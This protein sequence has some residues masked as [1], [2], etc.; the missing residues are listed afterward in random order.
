MY[1][2]VYV[3]TCISIE[4]W[5]RLRKYTFHGVGVCR[6]QADEKNNTYIYIYIY[7]YFY[8]YIYIYIYI[9]MMSVVNTWNN[10]L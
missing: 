10:H 2:E 8:I 9:Y 1:I 5:V 4:M 7:I 3:S 6:F